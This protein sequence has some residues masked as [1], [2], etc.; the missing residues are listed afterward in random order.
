[1]ALSVS[2]A[3]AVL[4]PRLADGVRFLAGG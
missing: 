1:V 3:L 2:L 4:A